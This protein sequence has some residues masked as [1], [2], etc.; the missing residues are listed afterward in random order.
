MK[1]ASAKPVSGYEP[2]NA[3][4]RDYEAW[5]DCLELMALL[6]KSQGVSTQDMPQT[7]R[8][9]LTPATGPKVKA[10]KRRDY[11]RAAMK[12]IGEEDLDAPWSELRTKVLEVIRIR[13]QACAGGYPFVVVN[14]EGFRISRCEEP[15]KSSASQCAYFFML[16]ATRMDMGKNRSAHLQGSRW[17]IEAKSGGAHNKEDW[18]D[19]AELFEKLCCLAI[20]GYLGQRCGTHHFGAGPDG[21]KM[22]LQEKFKEVEAT[23]GDEIQVKA[24]HEIEQVHGDGGLDL[25]AWVSF[26]EN[27]LVDVGQKRNGK[28]LIFGQCKTGTSYDLDAARRLDPTGIVE[29]FLK[30]AF[31]ISSTNIVRVFLIADRPDLNK[32]KKFN[33]AGGLLFDRCRITDCLE[34]APTDP[35]LMPQILNWTSA[36]QAFEGF[37]SCLPRL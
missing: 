4:S 33:R 21:A 17:R 28:M 13:E 10:K 8:Q 31:A 24:E 29:D 1:D 32:S 7:V 16:L 26:A 34:T 22:K 3:G 6:G 25:I 19:G 36:A 5:A 27:S 37:N 30:Q 23:F 14:Q 18:L 35:D 15:A 12:K 9:Q 2:P 20:K 11:P